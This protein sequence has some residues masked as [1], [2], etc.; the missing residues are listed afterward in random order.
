MNC[1][2]YAAVSD[3][4]SSVFPFSTAVGF[5]KTAKKKKK[6]KKS[7]HCSYF[8]HVR[9]HTKVNSNIIINGIIIIYKYSMSVKCF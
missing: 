2:C 6:K 4:E 1:I 8:L 9:I 7:K 5:A 3:C